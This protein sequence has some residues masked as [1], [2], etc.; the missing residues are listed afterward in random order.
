M[1]RRLLRSLIL[2]AV[3]LS[4]LAAA[5]AQSPPAVPS[6]PDQE[7][8]TTYSISSSTCG[9]SVGFAI[10]G[11]SNDVDS[12]IQV[13]VNGVRYLST[14]ANFGW[15]LSGTGGWT[16]SSVSTQARPLTDANL[17]FNTAQT[18]TVQVVGARRPR[19]LA[20]F[21]EGRGVAARDLNQRFTDVTAI[22]RELW[23]KTNDLTGRGLFSQPGVT[24][25]PMPQPS[26][27]ENSYIAFDSTGKNPVC[28]PGPTGSGGN[29]SGPATSTIG[30]VATWDN[31]AGTLLS[32]FNLFGTA[33]NW[34]AAQTF[35]AGGL[36]NDTTTVVGLGALGKF[37]TPAY[38]GNP[39]TGVVDRLNR[40]QIGEAA[41]TSQDVLSST[42]LPTTP[43]WI[44]SL[45][46]LNIVGSGQLSVVSTWGN[47]PIATASRASDY[48]NAL[49][50][51]SG[52]IGSVMAAYND[53]TTKGST[54]YPLLL[55]G[56]KKAGALGPTFALQADAL[57]LTNPAGSPTVLTP[58][59]SIPNASTESVLLTSG[60]FAAAV[61]N[62]SA[63]AVIALGRAGGPVFNKGI[64]CDNGALDTT[65]GAGGGGVCEEFAR[66]MSWR[67]LNS[68]GGVDAEWWG[69]ATG[70]NIA[71]AG[72]L[73][74][75]LGANSSGHYG[76]ILG[77]AGAQ[78]A[79][80]LLGYSGDKSL[81][82]RSDLEVSFSNYSGSVGYANFSAAG[83]LFYVPAGYT[84]G[85]GCAV[86]QITNRTTGVTC[87]AANGDITLVSA[88]GSATP[89]SF[90]VTNSAVGADDS[91]RLSQLSGTDKYE[92]FV[93]N[94]GS[95][96]FVV[97]FFTTGGTTT[98]QPVF[99]FYI[100]KGSNS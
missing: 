32:D 70:F 39:G 63:A 100:G 21:Q 1:K 64:I 42:N 51:A 40:V 58:Y 87:N 56:I 11:D 20:Q 96:S 27:C 98:E 16:Q 82:L 22:E 88:A 4:P 54:A 48:V 52:G 74:L 35:S 92:L 78:Y 93:T 73:G 6:L 34:T 19:Q 79:A 43:S 17:T 24:I 66:G 23:D 83:D 41:L 26:A 50:A 53:D 65:V 47:I 33:N 7:R 57:D 31:T 75:T 76:Q 61:T 95:G 15:S 29:V 49:G 46:S 86:T 9:C 67:V 59:N 99:K 84:T 71:T 2:L 25:G 37:Y 91:I 69:N 10:F 68:S 44:D 45:L 36:I 3:L 89:A 72:N 90:T 30:H 62:I 12:W 97:T 14:D 13:W 77:P 80:I 60:S 5:F 81:Y 8:R 55:L 85:A 94:T 28:L 38:F 18:G